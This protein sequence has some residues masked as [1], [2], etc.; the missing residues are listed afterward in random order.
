[1]ENNMNANER[2]ALAAC[3]FLL[4]SACGPSAQSLMLGKWEADSTMKVTAEFSRGG[5][6]KLTMFGQTL[7][8]TYELNA[9]SELVWTLNGKTTKSKVNVTTTEL[10]LTDAGNR[11]IRYKRK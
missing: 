5:T 2:I 6:A 9:E 1:V 11:T 10:E 7:Q 3:V 8:G 4:S